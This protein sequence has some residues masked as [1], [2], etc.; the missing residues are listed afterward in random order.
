[1]HVQLM[2]GEILKHMHL[3]GKYSQVDNL[4]YIECRIKH[5]LVLKVMVMQLMTQRP[6]MRNKSECHFPS[7]RN[8]TKLGQ[9]LTLRQVQ[10]VLLS[11]CMG[12]SSIFERSTASCIIAVSRAI[13]F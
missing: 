3:T 9:H 2:K 12:A 13:G 11:M 7:K 8:V 1:M 5:Q 6:V 10:T 4:G